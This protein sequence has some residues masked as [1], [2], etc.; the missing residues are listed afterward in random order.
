MINN[1]DIKVIEN[2]GISI[3]DA[4]AQIKGLSGGASFTKLI[5]SAH[6]GNGIIK[7]EQKKITELLECEDS[8]KEGLTISKF[9]PASGAASRMFSYLM[10]YLTDSE[11]SNETDKFFSNINKFP[12]ASLISDLHENELNESEKKSIISYLLT[13]EGLNWS[14]TPKGLLPFH[15]Y[16]EEFRTPFEEHLIEGAQYCSDSTGIL[17]VHLTISAEHEKLFKALY[18]EIKD[19]YEKQLGLTLEVNFSRQ[20]S[21]TDAIALTPQNELFR[22]DDGKILFRPGGHGS[23][24]N[25]LNLYPSDILLVKNIDNVVQDSYKEN[26]CKWF[27]IITAL[28]IDRQKAINSMIISLEN[29]ESDETFTNELKENAIELVLR[30]CGIKEIPQ[31]VQKSDTKLKDWIYKKLN[32]PL[33]VCGVVEYPEDTGGGPFWIED[34]NKEITLQIVETAQMNKSDNKQNIIASSSRYFNPVFMALSLKNSKG[35]SYILDKYCDKSSFFVADKSYKGRKLKAYEHPGLW[36]GAMAYWNTIFIEIP[37]DCF[38]P[39][40]SVN[41]LLSEQHN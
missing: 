39:V 17:R 41:D 25:N 27:R 31:K 24:L 14:G 18:N 22:D 6:V 15:R 5:D 26:T 9:V 13:Q 40:K 21:S 35:D 28:T 12:F 37:Q 34:S 1:E 23:L 36:N 32:R 19:K 10:K 33:R 8:L 11:E 16:G 4:K 29:C 20:N 7:L 3:E 38:F 2:H 30:N